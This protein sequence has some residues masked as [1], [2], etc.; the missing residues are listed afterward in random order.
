MPFE[1]IRHTADCSIRVWAQDMPSLLSEAARGMNSILGLQLNEAHPYNKEIHLT[2]FDYESLMVAF[3]SE[4]IYMVERDQIGFENISI[5]LD[6][7]SLHAT[8][9]G[10]QINSMGKTVKAVTFHNLKI[11]KSGD[12]LEAVL[13]FDV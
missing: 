5:D 1:E 6:D 9:Q 13:V 8:L 4:L 2:A 11:I 12:F 3:L 10:A 7:T